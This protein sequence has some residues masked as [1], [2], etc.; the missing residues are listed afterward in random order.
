MMNVFPY[1]THENN[2][3]SDKLATHTIATSLLESWADLVCHLIFSFSS[4][5]RH[6]R[7]TTPITSLNEFAKSHRGCVNLSVFDG[8]LRTTTSI[9][10]CHQPKRKAI[11]TRTIMPR[12]NLVTFDRNIENEIMIEIIETGIISG[13]GTTPLIGIVPERD[14]MAMM[15]TRSDSKGLVK[16]T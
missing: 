4:H 11:T 14:M 3:P 2:H 13:I 5:I 16:S 15:M 8:L 9:T 1:K 7:Y 12:L 6:C 10:I